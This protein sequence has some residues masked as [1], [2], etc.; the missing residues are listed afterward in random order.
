[1]HTGLS[2]LNIAGLLR[3]K[4]TLVCLLGMYT[5][6]VIQINELTHM[7]YNYMSVCAYTQL[8]IHMVPICH[9]KINNAL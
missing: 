7:V 3:I 9:G 2:V 1:M 8:E 4:A 5:T 6:Y